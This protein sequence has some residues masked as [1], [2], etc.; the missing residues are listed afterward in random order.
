MKAF[1]FFNNLD[2]SLVT[3]ASLGVNF[4]MQETLSKKLL[5][6]LTVVCLF[7]VDNA[8]A[9]VGS[10]RRSMLGRGNLSFGR[11]LFNLKEFTPINLHIFQ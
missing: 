8:V 6:S 1:P 5:S 11:T 4:L 10:I 9:L 7:M 3:K 2:S